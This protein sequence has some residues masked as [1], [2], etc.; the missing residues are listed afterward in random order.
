[1]NTLEFF[2]AILPAEGV[3][4]LAIFK[5]SSKAPTHK[6]FDSLDDMAQAVADIEQKH[7]EWTIYHACAAYKESF[8]EVDGKKKYRVKDNWKSAQAFWCDIDCGQDKAD[9][10][11]GYA[12]KRLAAEALVNFC[13]ATGFPT[14]MFIDSGNGIHCYWPL[15]KAIPA[16]AWQAMAHVVCYYP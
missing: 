9:E 6:A 5:P 16:N 13:K 3:H 7:P 2:K 11:K 1:M 14:P 10:G 15:T 8:V 4:F 12:T